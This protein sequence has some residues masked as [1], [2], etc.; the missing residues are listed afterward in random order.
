MHTNRAQKHAD[1]PIYIIIKVL[2][3]T[4]AKNLYLVYRFQRNYVPAA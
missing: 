3:L 4:I 2:I 1:V